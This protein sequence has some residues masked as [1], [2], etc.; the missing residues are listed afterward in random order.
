M[1]IWTIIFI[2]TVALSV[3]VSA[4]II[5][6]QPQGTPPPDQGLPP[7]SIRDLPGI[8]LVSGSE[9]VITP[10]NRFAH[11]TTEDGLSNNAVTTILQDRRGFMWIGTQDGL[12][13]FDGYRF[14]IYRHNPKNSNS[15]SNNYIEDI[16]EDRDGALWIATQNGVNRLDQHTG[17]IVRYRLDPE[18]P[19]SFGGNEIKTIFQDSAG[20]LW[21]AGRPH[22]G[23]SKLNPS[24]DRI[25]QHDLSAQQNSFFGV[26]MALEDRLH[27]GVFWF[28]GGP[29][30]L[31]FIPDTQQLTVYAPDDRGRFLSSLAQD[32]DGHIWFGDS[33]GLNEFDP[34]TEQF[35][36]YTTTPP[37]YVSIVYQD[38]AGM[39]W[40]GSDAQGL[41]RFNPRTKQFIE[42]YAYRTADVHGLSS[43]NITA[44]YEDAAGVLWI[45]TDSAGL[46]LYDPRR[47]QFTHYRYDLDDPRGLSVS[48]IRS[49]CGDE[50]GK[51]WLNFGYHLDRFDP[52]VGTIH[53]QFQIMNTR[54][55]PGFHTIS[56][57][58]KGG[59]WAGLQDMIFHLDAGSDDTQ[60]YDPKEEI[61]PHDPRLGHVSSVFEDPDG[62][63]WI[64]MMA[65]GMYRVD[66]EHET[67]T[68]YQFNPLE[69]PPSDPSHALNSGLVTVIFGDRAG[70]IWLGYQDNGVSRYDP[71]TQTFTHFT[72]DPGEPESMPAGWI[73][74]MYEDRSGKM[75]FGSRSGL[76]HFDPESEHFTL[77]TEQ[78]GLPSTFI[79]GI[80]EDRQGYLWLSTKNGLSRFDPRTQS[81]RNYDV[82]DGL[83][84]NEFSS[85][86]AW[87]G[88]DGRLYFGGTNGI[89][90][91]YPDRMT[92]NS[93]MPPLVLT[94]LRVDNIPLTIGEDSR[95]PH[96]LWDI[97]HLTF[98]PHDHVISFQFA[99][100]SYARSHKNR[101]RYHLEGFDK[102]WNEVDSAR[103]FATYT[104]LDAGK[105]VFRVQ[106]TNNSRLWSDREAVL[107]ITVLPSW[108]EATWFRGAV[109]AALIGTAFGLYWWRI[110]T[111]QR[112]K[113]LLAT[114]VA[115]RTREL[116][117]EKDKAVIL[118]ERAEV[119]N[120][121]KSTFLANMSHELRSPLNAIL[122]FAQVLTRSRTLSSDD[123]ENIGIIRRSGEHLLTLIN[124][125]LDLSKIE[126][127]RM[128]LNAKD[129]DLHRLLDE[130]QDMFAMRAE[131]KGL[132]LLFER[133]KNVP[134]YIRTD[135]VKLRQVLINLLNN[136]I[137]FTEEGGVA[138]RILD[139]GFQNVDVEDRQTAPSN[140]T[141][142]LIHLKFEIEDS[143]PGIAQE[144]VEQVFEAFG[145]TET[146]RQSK[147]GTGLGLPLSRKF[148]HLMDGDMQVKSEVGHGTLFSFD[149]Q[150]QIVNGSDLKPT[151]AVRRVIAL[152][153]GQP[154]YRILVV[155]DRWTNRQ[156][157]VKLLNP[158]GFDL[159][160]AANGQEAVEIWDNWRPHLIWM[161]MRM[162]VLDG[163]DATKR[164][165][166]M[167]QDRETAI[168]ALTA[169]SLEEERAIV[170]EAGCDDYL[171]K[172]FR[173]NELF[174]LMST[175][176]GVTFVY[177][178]GKQPAESLKQKAKK[179]E[180]LQAEGLASLPAEWQTTLKLAAEETDVD[181]LRGLVD[182]IRERD[183]AVADAL[184]QLVEDFEYDEILAIIQQLHE[185][186]DA[187]EGH[188]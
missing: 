110:S 19:N 64:G 161:D 17:T 50:S 92:E 104:D 21:F 18:N 182:Q 78:E 43:N 37:S 94:E 23:L 173:E 56:C 132:Q 147:E 172:P 9:V 116:Q 122:G 169:S 111:I 83:Q 97:E 27:N 39:F 79:V 188:I 185:G 40:I 123:Q 157:V 125:V 129:F 179:T 53:P 48:A 163:Y 154:R 171:R 82:F 67:Y 141:S 44:L 91:F 63:L 162:P 14:T 55:G 3:S 87:K 121:A 84:G 76:I 100:L 52:S 77:Y 85:K 2:I 183:A 134:R 51:L 24:T 38:T 158:L 174:E 118:R 5:H 74:A 108:W 99:A 47:A 167:M 11:L 155:D 12:N 45:G 160:E 88:P 73:E 149:I 106:G 102:T 168:I 128:T 49:L 72:P 35:S 31:K 65:V 32:A 117:T 107:H 146:G 69:P 148:V 175:H 20:T 153:P 71:Q 113:Q 8:E 142:H 10:S 120:Q 61:P 33:S 81:F 26:F 41:Y 86:S 133:G 137:K 159:R 115:D 114:L 36:I 144:E 89:T 152:H 187:V 30:L 130:T 66:P 15:L 13:R 178:D 80:Q 98:L 177:E 156:L 68:A 170:L 46:N 184:A 96:P 135:E 103:R 54:G 126:A 138:V 140:H 25:I 60:S 34:V 186:G 127:G 6:A 150:A 58:R 109:L 22:V 131:T 145:Q 29:Q 16:L 180:R 75:W 124:Q 4:R 165:R 119:A 143:G 7:D 28:A 181:V 59:V 95:L 164:I 62:V 42:H 139:L 101:Y 136:A 70:H 105:Y 90:A 57:D 166:T 151:R 93:Y 1:K 176:I 112:Q